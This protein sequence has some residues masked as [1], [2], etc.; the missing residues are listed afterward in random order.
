MSIKY[1]NL[2]WHTGSVNL[3]GIKEIVYAVAKRD[4]VTW[5]TRPTSFT[6]NMAELAS[7]TGNFVL[8]ASIY[9]TKIGILVDKSPIE[10]KTQ[11]TK[12]S[13]TVLNSATFVHAGVDGEA[14]GFV[15]QANND[16]MVYI[17]VQKN[18]QRRIIG[19]DMYQ[20]N[21]DF[22]QKLGGAP[23][24]E[25][26]TTL[27]ATVTDICLPFYKGTIELSATEIVPALT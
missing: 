15:V 23:T 13:K 16:D 1:K 5:P 20:T 11:G 4:I 27:T 25:M 17:A 18:G 3:P 14:A 10:S 21:T 19:N 7:Y 12:P 8:A 6:T 24:D 26:G 22:D 2:D 9:W